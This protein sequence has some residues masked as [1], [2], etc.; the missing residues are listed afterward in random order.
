MN[1]EVK[2]MAK[3]A[4]KPANF[5]ERILMLIRARKWDTIVMLGL[6]M[7]LSITAPVTIGVTVSDGIKEAL[8]PLAVSLEETKDSVQSLEDFNITSLKNSA[9]VA[10]NKIATIE[11][12]I[13]LT[14]NGLAIR[15][16]LRVPE[17]REVLI[18]IDKARTEE[19]ERFF[20]GD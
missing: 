17:I 10:Y 6:L 13:P 2:Q 7:L 18:V 4:E 9:I 1:E 20:F 11:D 3:D 12:L 19:F 16:G 8:E 15:E 14:Q 5:L